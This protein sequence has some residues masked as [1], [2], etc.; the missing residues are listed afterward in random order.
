[1]FLELEPAA[2]VYDVMSKRLETL[3]SHVEET[4]ES[5]V[6]GLEKK[7][8]TT[9]TQQDVEAMAAALKMELIDHVE[10]RW[11]QV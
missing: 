6:E 11:V 10:S 7:L 3:E 1:L 8:D 2:V 4:L 5:H 9:P